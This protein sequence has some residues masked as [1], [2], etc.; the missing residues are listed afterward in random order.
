MSGPDAD[1]ASLKVVIRGLIAEAR[2]GV[3][4]E[5]RATPQRLRLDVELAVAPPA[6]LGPN[7][8]DDIGAVY[9]YGALRARL[10]SLCREND[11]KLLET[12]ADRILRDCLGDPRVIRARVRIE[13]PDIFEDCEGIGIE[14]EAR[15]ENP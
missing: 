11:S 8:A 6:G 15:A 3:G 10:I 4:E 12:L 2:I 9:D 14:I 13:K 7:F 1:R 5:E